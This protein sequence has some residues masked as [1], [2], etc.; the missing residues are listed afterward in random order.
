ML[1]NIRREKGWKECELVYVDMV[2]A[3]MA[4]D[5]TAQVYSNKSSSTAVRK[6]LAE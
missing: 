4:N 2:L 5:G 3:D 1:N 6:Y